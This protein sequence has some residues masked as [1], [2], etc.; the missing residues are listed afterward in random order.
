MVAGEEEKCDKGQDEESH[1]DKMLRGDTAI[2][3]T[4]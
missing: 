3:I 1:V 4:A 2:V